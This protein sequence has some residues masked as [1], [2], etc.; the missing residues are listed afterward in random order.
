MSELSVWKLEDGETHW[1]VAADEADAKEVLAEDMRRCGLASYLVEEIESC[2]RLDAEY[3][4]EISEHGEPD[5]ESK[6]CARWAADSGRGYLCGSC[7]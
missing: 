7:W 5:A 3:V 1:V 2:E 4:L 6:S